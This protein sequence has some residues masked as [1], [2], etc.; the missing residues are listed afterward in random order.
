MMFR[1][2]AAWMAWYHAV[3]HA[4]V[5]ESPY[6]REL[7]GGDVLWNHAHSD[8]QMPKLVCRYFE[9]GVAKWLPMFEGMFD[10]PARAALDQAALDMVK[11]IKQYKPKLGGNGD[12]DANAETQIPANKCRV[13]NHIC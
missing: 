2:H 11:K 10:E 3:C 4:Y 13:L 9:G 1:K 6:L 12:T 7:Y 8:A 5:T